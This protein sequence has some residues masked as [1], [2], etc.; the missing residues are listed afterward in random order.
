MRKSK[1]EWTDATWNP[2]T[3]CDHGCHYCYARRMAYR[4]R[5]RA[6]YPQ[7]EP[8]R[9]TF[10]ENRLEQP[11]KWKGNK[12]VFICS[13]GELFSGKNPN[14]WLTE[15]FDVIRRCPQH[16]FIV[17]TKQPQNLCFIDDWPDNVWVGI[18]IDGLSEPELIDRQLAYLREVKSRVRFISFEPLL[19]SVNVSL[20]G[21]DWVII[22]QQ[23]GQG[24]KKA[25]PRWVQ[26]LIERARMDKIPVF[27]KDNLNW[28]LI[29]RE[30]PNSL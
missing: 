10:H 11:L 28:Q 25:N 19:S 29:I 8:F 27:L 21:I 20:R 7:D 22:G 15:V 13:M 9:P 5:G 23:S 26:Y 14:F 3:G 6:G 2:I 24:A 1:I 16:T 30:F 4:L 18:S 17:L 12:K